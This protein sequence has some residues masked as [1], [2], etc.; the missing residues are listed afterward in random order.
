MPKILVTGG[1]GYIGSQTVKALS[2]AGF[3][4]VVVDNLSAGHK[5]SIAGRADL[6]ICDV[7]D[8]EKLTEVFYK[9]RPDAVIDFAA[10]LSVG[11]SMKN[12]KKYLKNNVENFV[13]LLDVM[14]KTECKYIIKS[15]TASTYGN[16]EDDKE[17]PLIEDY[18]ERFQPEASCLL[19]GE[20][21]GKKVEGEEFFQKFVGAFNSIY[22]YRPELVLNS[23]ELT[24]L[25]IPLSIYGLSKLLDEVLLK[26]YDNVSGIKS[27]ALRYFNVCG[28]DPDGEIGEDKPSPT[29]LMVLCLYQI[30]GK[31]PPIKV[32]GNDYPTSDG[33][34]IRDY[35]HVA[36]IAEGHISA[37]NYLLENSTSD[38]FNLGTGS[39][40]SVFEVIKA[41]NNASEKSVKYEV[42]GRRSGDPAISI[43]NPKKANKILDWSAKFNLSDMAESA[44]KWHLNHPNGYVE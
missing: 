22:A 8:K 40:K 5:E 25:R 16:P 18:T 1:A 31:I 12:P 26:K 11:E 9:H 37:L 17:I 36:D 3:S 42:V 4:I 15:S 28:A 6:E 32:F 35:I 30:L 39:G 20:W 10:Y 24:K 27:I 44:Y 13:T 23:G 38:T 2:A 14:V 34:G 41:V 21:D 7:E 19:D 29:T 43:A 33:T